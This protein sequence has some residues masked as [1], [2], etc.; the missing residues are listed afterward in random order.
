MATRPRVQR[1]VWNSNKLVPVCLTPSYL[2]LLY[3]LSKN[4]CFWIKSVEEYEREYGSAMRAKFSQAHWRLIEGVS[5]VTIL[6]VM[7]HRSVIWAKVCSYIV[8]RVPII[9]ADFVAKN[10]SNGCCSQHI[11]TIIWRPGSSST[12]LCFYWKQ[13]AA[14]QWR[15][16]LKSWEYW[17][18]HHTSCHRVESWVLYP[19]W[20]S[21]N[22]K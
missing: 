21:N 4:K 11:F 17:E 3:N 12:N 15:M 18:A 1:Q 10:L 16:L 14:P 7:F 8:L 20:H 6:L 19:D 5:V 13:A 2:S 22:S 9:L